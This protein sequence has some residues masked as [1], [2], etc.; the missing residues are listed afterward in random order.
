[1]SLYHEAAEV[2]RTLDTAAGSLKNR[3][4]KRKDLKAP[5]AQ[6]YALAIESCKW[7]GVLK[8]V[9]DASDLLKAERKLTPILALLLV[10]D[11]L[12]AK[13]GISLPAS[14][15]LRAA[16]E[17]H[18][19]RL[20]SEL[21]RARLRRKMP[22][23]Q[24]LRAL[25]ARDARA[26]DDGYPRWIRV[27]S[28]RSDIATELA[29]TFAAYVQVASLAELMQAAPGTAIHVDQHVPNLLAA[30]PGTDVTKTDSYRDGRIILQDKASCFPAY[31]LDPQPHHGDVVDGCAAPGNKTTHVAAILAER[32]ADAHVDAGRRALVYAYEKSRP[33]S[34]ILTK[35]VGVAGAKD[36]VRIAFGQDF[37][38]TDPVSMGFVGALLLDPSCSGSGI[39]GR[40]ANPTLHVPTAY[41]AGAAAGAGKKRKREQEE[42]PLAVAGAGAAPAERVLLDDD[43]EPVYAAASAQDLDARLR[44]LAA[45]QTKIVLHALQF[46]AA[47]RVTYSTCS[48]HAE[49]NEGVVLAVLASEEARRGG[50]R[51]L[52][53]EEQVRGMREWPVRGEVA[54]A[55]GDEEVAQA[56]VRAYKGDGRGVMGFFV[57]G[58]VRDEIP[59][60]KSE[61][62]GE[63]ADAEPYVRDAEGVIVREQGTGMPLEKKTGRF[64]ELKADEKEES[65]DGSDGDSSSESDSAASSSEEEEEWGGF[66]D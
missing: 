15:G 7:S 4:F 58:F 31:L 24:A 17:R 25:V 42:T 12:L 51:M 44:A 19:G 66:D 13:G 29:T 30:A 20:S 61:G 6:V 16:V 62:E 2:L 65:A 3:V 26:E 40:D 22:S 47:R 48:V 60:T 5:P 57:A 46:P 43:G 36:A 32:R 63:G 23:L 49:E 41:S 9:I 52:K 11:L 59:G 33:R 35:M 34:D 21:T 37:L 55:E 18:K 45:F 8:E 27:N 38:R 54:A 28:L 14:H 50:W 64:V 1:M 10:H 53:R 56:C 39:V